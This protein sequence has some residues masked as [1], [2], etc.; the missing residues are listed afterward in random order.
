MS[1]REEIGVD[2]L[3]RLYLTAVNGLYTGPGGSKLKSADLQRWWKQ[4]TQEGYTSSNKDK[5]KHRCVA[6]TYGRPVVLVLA[7]EV[8]QS[9]VVDAEGKEVLGENGRPTYKDDVNAPRRQKI[10]VRAVTVK[11]GGA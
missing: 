8:G 2:G 5:V 1:K 9:K 4:L 7:S 11:K 10:Q 3:G 6:D